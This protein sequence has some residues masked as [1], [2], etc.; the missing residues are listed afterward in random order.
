MK[1]LFCFALV[2]L[3]L[4]AI[5]TSCSA[6][7]DDSSTGF[8]GGGGTGGE[9]I[10]GGGS[11]GGGGT[12]GCTDAC[13][14]GA[15]KCTASGTGTIPCHFD[16]SC[17][18]WGMPQDCP[19]GL[20]CSNGVC[21]EECQDECNEGSRKCEGNGY[22][23]CQNHD[24]DPCLDWGPAT[25]CPSGQ[26]CS[27]GYCSE[28]CS[29]ECTDGAKRCAGKGTQTCGDYDADPCLEWGSIVPCGAGETCSNGVC[30]TTCEEECATDGDTQC[31]GGG[32]AF[33]TCGQYDSDPCLEWGSATSCPQNQTCVEG[34]CVVP[35]D[36][37]FVDGICEAAAPNSSSACSCDTDCL[38]AS[39]CQDDGHCDSWCPANLDS[40]CGC[41]C[42]YNEHCEAG[43][44]HNDWSPPPEWE[45]VV[46]CACDPECEPGEYAC[47]DDGH[48]DTWC[49]PEHDPDCGTDPCRDRRMLVG[50]RQ[51]D[52]LTL[53]GD[54]TLPDADEG[55]NWV[56]LSP[57]L[58]SAEAQMLVQFASEHVA[59]VT[60]I[61]I[62]VFGYDDATFGD[63]AEMY[64]RN[65][66]TDVYDLLPVTVTNSGSY[67][68]NVVD[69]VTPYLRCESDGKCW[70]DAKL[71][72]SAWD[73][74]HVGRFIVWVHME[75]L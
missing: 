27:N 47:I 1:R 57:G 30:G 34:E 14:E 65:W 16:G 33:E 58:S 71:L 60:E 45:D 8:S 5:V 39:A 23:V 20:T 11:G 22:Q 61:V 25:A 24:A 43:E 6:E 12:T 68:E 36:C 15:V 75:P 50:M 26:T 7:D 54:Y 69:D 31:T 21:S 53:T 10:G 70:V 18:V 40:D 4:G 55:D 48:C 35:C 37:D 44:N 2:A 66:Q 62:Q 42:D 46:T 49:L 9:P 41:G 3:G 64:L 32:T 56:L 67:H 17:W 13:S 72:A 51:G 19:A 74:T 29:N 63:G 59:C 38:G 73:N 52:E 28:N